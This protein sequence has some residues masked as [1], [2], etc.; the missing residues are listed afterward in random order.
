MTS[1]IEVVDPEAGAVVFIGSAYSTT[2]GN[3][4]EADLYTPNSTDDARLT[5]SNDDYEAKVDLDLPADEPV[6][7]RF[8][9]YAA[10]QG[11]LADEFVT[12]VDGPGTATLV[13]QTATNA[14]LAP[15]EYDLTVR[16][17]A[18]G[19]PDD[20]TTVAI[21]TRE[22]EAITALTSDTL[23]PEELSDPE[24][25]ATARE[26]GTVTTSETIDDDET[27]L[28]AVDATGL[29][30]LLAAHDPITSLDDV[31]DHEGLGLDV[32][33]VDVD[34]VD[35][36]ADDAEEMPRA[37]L[38]DDHLANVSTADP[39]DD[40]LHA[41][42]RWNDLAFENGTPSTDDEL[43]LRF[44]V[45]D[46]RLRT[47]DDDATADPDAVTTTLTYVGNATKSDDGSV[48]SDADDGDGDDDI[49]GSDDDV[50]ASST[51][52][53]S[54][55][56]SDEADETDGSGGGDDLDGNDA[57]TGD[58]GDPEDDEDG[59]TETEAVT[60]PTTT[61]ATDAVN[62]TDAANMTD[63]ANA[64]GASDGGDDS[65][66]PGGSGATGGSSPSSGSGSSTGRSDVSGD[67]DDLSPGPSTV[68]SRMLPPHVATSAGVNPAGLRGANS[69]R[70]S[71]VSAGLHG[72]DRGLPG[73]ESDARAGSPERSDEA[74]DREGVALS[75]LDRVAH[76]DDYGWVTVGDV[77]GFGP[78]PALLALLLVTMRLARRTERSDA[79]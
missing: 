27:L 8:D 60:D 74:A 12:V 57:D 10:G 45:T 46:D 2:R 25:V 26:N 52:D 47:A 11:D 23:G 30:G 53:T 48:S 58:A 35:D 69:D 67:R 63:A 16:G 34:A 13:D 20:E 64:T 76:D 78:V 28:V 32:A 43:R 65:T 3:N 71:G 51:E 33:V 15:G 37:T 39:D 49:V 79:S 5:F 36:D 40:G 19:D 42:V 6:T 38:T 22:T 4:F 56:M 17:A 7:L 66:S 9:T 59:A 72:F 1:E 18:D 14:T 24:S 62:E 75:D 41:A 77:P 70:A 61:N 21:E 29:G 44:A 50:T 73:W 68:H 55:D 54:E 31:A